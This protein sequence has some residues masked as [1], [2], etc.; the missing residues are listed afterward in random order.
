M[1]AYIH[2]HASTPTQ[3]AAPSRRPAA[4]RSRFYSQQMFR[5]S[6]LSVSHLSARPRQHRR[7]SQVPASLT[8]R[9]IVRGGRFTWRA[10][11]DHPLTRA[12]GRPDPVQISVHQ[13]KPTRAPSTE[14][15][16]RCGRRAIELRSSYSRSWRSIYYRVVG[17]GSQVGARQVVSHLLT[18]AGVCR[19]SS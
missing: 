15:D 17:R 10:R 16:G 9:R 6:P 11:R 14:T 7:I 5:R 3:G 18:R 19:R 12:R 2:A 1:S 8:H 4:R 13:T